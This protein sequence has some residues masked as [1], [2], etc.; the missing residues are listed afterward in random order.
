[1]AYAVAQR[2]R[3]IGVRL[4]L[5]AQPRDVLNMVLV[6]GGKLAAFGLALGLIGSLGMSY[7]CAAS[8]TASPRAI[9]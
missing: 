6:G 9:P 7:F 8:S 3:E 1:M 2:T 4:A 5:G